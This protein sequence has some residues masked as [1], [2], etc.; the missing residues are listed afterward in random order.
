MICSYIISEAGG[1]ALGIFRYLRLIAGP[2]AT[3]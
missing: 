2:A 3:R 1:R